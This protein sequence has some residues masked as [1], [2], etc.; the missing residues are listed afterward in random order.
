MIRT[1]LA[2]A[3]ACGLSA[4]AAQ[5]PAPAPEPSIVYRDAAVAV[6]VSCVVD[7]PA[8]V[9]PLRE[10][11]APAEWRTRAPGAKVQ[12]IAAQAGRRM[13]HQT[14]SDAATSGCTD[15]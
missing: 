2:L 11:V 1:I 14:L 13:S 10:R 8:P 6:P 15:R 3:I 5:L 12:A 4:C 7:R 9:V